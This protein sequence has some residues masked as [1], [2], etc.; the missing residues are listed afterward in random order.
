MIDE[1]GMTK[2]NEIMPLFSLSW[3]KPQTTPLADPFLDRH[4]GETAPNDRADEEPKARR[5]VEQA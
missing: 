1:T 4:V 5:N 3:G 2:K